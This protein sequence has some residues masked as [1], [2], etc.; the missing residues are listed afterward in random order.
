MHEIIPLYMIKLNLRILRSAWRMSQDNS[1][2][3]IR[4]SVNAYRLYDTRHPLHMSLVRLE[5]R[6]T[7]QTFSPGFLYSPHFDWPL[8]AYSTVSMFSL[9]PGNQGSTCMFPSMFSITNSLGPRSARTGCCQHIFK[10]KIRTHIRGEGTR[11]YQND[12]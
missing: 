1:V 9:P 2:A 11:R 6:S 8:H 3:Y 10:E 7:V 4:P 12:V 5:L